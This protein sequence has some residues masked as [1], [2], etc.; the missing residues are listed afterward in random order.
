M[1]RPGRP[2]GPG[3][4]GGP[5]GPGQPVP[6]RPGVP[7]VPEEQLGTSQAGA[8][9]SAQDEV[10]DSALKKKEEEHVKNYFNVE[11]ILLNFNNS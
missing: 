11:M 6:G 3:G 1:A 9:G 8:Q 2:G 5:L 10:H 4:P 7:G